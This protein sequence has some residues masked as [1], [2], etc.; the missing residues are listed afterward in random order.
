MQEGELVLEDGAT[1]S[2]EPFREAEACWD[3]MGYVTIDKYHVRGEYELR[4]RR[5]QWVE[6]NMNMFHKFMLWDADVRLAEQRIG[7]MV[8]SALDAIAISQ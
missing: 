5:E 1:S 7:D 4:Y 6:K 8:A 2:V 3:H